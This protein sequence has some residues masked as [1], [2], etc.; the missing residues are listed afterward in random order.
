[1]MRRRLGVILLAATVTCGLAGLIPLLPHPLAGLAGLVVVTVGGAAFIRQAWRHSR[2]AGRLRQAS[3]PGELA[4]IPV[5]VGDLGGGAFVAGLL[6][7]EVFCDHRLSGRLTEAEA[8]AVAL[9]ERAHQRARDPLRLTAVAALAPLVAR[10]PGGPA[11]LARISASPEIAADRAA[12]EAGASRRALIAA[13]FKTAPV[14]WAHVPGFAPAVDLRLRA[15]LD[16]RPE[17]S[18]GAGGCAL[19]GV[20]AGALLCVLLLHA[21]TPLATTVACCA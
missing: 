6:D 13:L 19:A 9:H 4:G 21:S 8:R 15:L 12:I 18:P 5:R 14:D 2:L 1:M 11:L 10:L 16:G 17:P 7:P 20:G 3:E